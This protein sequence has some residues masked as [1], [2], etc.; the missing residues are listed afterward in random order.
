[1]AEDLASIVITPTEAQRYLLVC[2]SQAGAVPARAL[3]GSTALVPPSC[4][5][6]DPAARG[7]L[8]DQRDRRGCSRVMDA[9]PFMENTKAELRNRSDKA[10]TR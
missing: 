4:C 10:N 3:T 1:M 2:R 7:D 8:G 9:G 5:Q 6:G